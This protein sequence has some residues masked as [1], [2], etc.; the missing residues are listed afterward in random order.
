MGWG[1]VQTTPPPPKGDAPWLLP[2]Y[3]LALFRLSDS[4]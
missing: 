4:E 1:M 2:S 3:L